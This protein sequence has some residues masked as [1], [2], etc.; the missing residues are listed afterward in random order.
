MHGSLLLLGASG[1]PA[2]AQA[3]PCRTTDTSTWLGWTL[4]AITN[5]DFVR[6]L[7]AYAMTLKS[8]KRAGPWTALSPDI[9]SRAG[10]IVEAGYP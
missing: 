7:R 6:A 5:V 4:S 10:C 9:G 1:G 8:P 2:R 3:R